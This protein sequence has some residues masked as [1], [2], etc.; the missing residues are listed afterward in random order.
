MIE[1]VGCRLPASH[2]HTSMVRCPLMRERLRAQNHGTTRD[3]AL[4]HTRMLRL[5]SIP[6]SGGENTRLVRVSMAVTVGFEPTDLNYRCEQLGRIQLISHGLEQPRRS[7]RTSSI[8]LR[9]CHS[10]ATHL[11]SGDGQ[12]GACSSHEA[13]EFSV[14]RAREPQRDRRDPLSACGSGVP[15]SRNWRPRASSHFARSL[16]ISRSRSLVGDRFGHR[17]APSVL[18]MAVAHADTSRKLAT[19]ELR[20]SPCDPSPERAQI[21]NKKPA[22]MEPSRSTTKS[23]RVSP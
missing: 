10:V 2:L 17:E 23:S 6:L 12:T 15:P 16:R 18:G 3:A 19:Y 8:Q 4:S 5:H 20:C 14:S 21:S 7:A 22:T 13:I 1:G 11:H 9:C